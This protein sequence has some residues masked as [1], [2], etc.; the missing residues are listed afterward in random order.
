MIAQNEMFEALPKPAPPALPDV[1]RASELARARVATRPSRHA[2]L[3]RELPSGG[4]PRS[5]LIEVLCQQNGGGEVQLL[6]PALAE[7]AQSQRVALIQPPYLPNATAC[8]YLGIPPDK[9]VWLRPGSGADALWCAEQILKKNCGFG[10][11][12]L[13]Q[14]NV[15]SESLRRLNLAAQAS[16]TWFWMLRPLA[17]AADPSPSPL[18]LALRPAAGAVTVDILKRRGPQCEQPLLVPL[19]DLPTRET[20]LEVEHEKLDQRAPAATVPRMHQTA[21]V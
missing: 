11:V 13:W 16:D 2:Q 21:L 7:L 17:Q 5:V 1:W 18:R 19:P 12:L 9:L 15:R 10:A 4:W 20:I 3:D 8:D 6:R 14:T